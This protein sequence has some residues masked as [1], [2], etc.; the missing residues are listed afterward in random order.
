MVVVQP[1][2][3]LIFQYGASKIMKLLYR[4]LYSEN[5][6]CTT[7]IHETLRHT[8]ILSPA[9]MVANMTVQYYLPG[10]NIKF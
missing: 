4:H 8:Q 5:Q 9:K 3:N 6:K 2:P 10:F 1:L 7:T